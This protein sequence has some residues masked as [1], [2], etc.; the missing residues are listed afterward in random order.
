VGCVTS[1]IELTAAEDGRSHRVTQAVYDEGINNGHGR[2][3][4]ACGRVV[5]AASLNTAPGPDC[6]LCT[7]AVRTAHPRT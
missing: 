2:Y 7:A 5:L 6:L 3:A 1:Y 4:A